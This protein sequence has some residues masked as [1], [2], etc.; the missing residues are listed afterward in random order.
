M[1]DRWARGAEIACGGTPAMSG[2]CR[3]LAVWMVKMYLR[4]EP[5]RRGTVI[6]NL[7]KD[8]YVRLMRERN[9]RTYGVEIVAEP[10]QDP[11][12]VPSRKRKATQRDSG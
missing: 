7:H 3:N 9:K 8:S 2:G 10:F 12:E 5:Y 1:P 11:T 4:G 6:C